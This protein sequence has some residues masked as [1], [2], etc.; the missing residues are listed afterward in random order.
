MYQEKPLHPLVCMLLWKRTDN[1]PDIL[2]ALDEQIK[3]D[4]TFSIWCNDPEVDRESIEELAA[5]YRSKGMDIDVYFHE[6]NAGSKARFA[7][8]LRL[9]GNPI[10]F[11]DDDQI[12][13][14]TFVLHMMMA[15]MSDPFGIHAQHNRRFFDESYQTAVIAPPG[16]ETD[17]CGTG[18][19][20]LPRD[21]I[22]DRRI[23]LIPAEF[24]DAEDLWLSF[25]ARKHLG[26]KLYSTGK[27]LD[28]RVDKHDQFWTIGKKKEKYFKRLRDMGWRLLKD[29]EVQSDR[30]SQHPTGEQ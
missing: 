27:K 10:L 15:W 7:Q 28:H 17:Y 19:M 23:Q 6:F 4:F 16:K 1:L 3:P 24:D 12:P 11:F 9:E 29:E 22:E 21:I 13:H 20:I 8:A 30:D 14:P 18:G 25:V 2:K 5:K 26:R